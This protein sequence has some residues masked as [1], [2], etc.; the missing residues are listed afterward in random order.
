MSANDMLFV[1]KSNFRVFHADA[2]GCYN[3][4]IGQGKSLEEAIKIAEDWEDEQCYPA[5]YGI[6]FCK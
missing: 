4:L 6:K 5:E 1:S 3:T 2:D